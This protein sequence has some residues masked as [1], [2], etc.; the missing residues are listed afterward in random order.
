M[1]KSK[2]TRYQVEMTEEQLRL[3]IDCIEDCSR[4]MAGQTEMTNC[5][6]RLDNNHELWNSL[7][8]LQ[9][10]VTPALGCGSS[11]SW[12][13]GHCPNEQQR[14]FIAQ[15]YYLY[16]EMRHRLTTA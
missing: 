9:P 2:Q 13:G 5:T 14:K 15:T 11:Y 10:L 16:R 7:R 1:K 6:A 4:F 12:N 8:E 3:V